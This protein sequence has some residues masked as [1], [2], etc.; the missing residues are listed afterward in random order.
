M[1][2]ITLTRIIGEYKP[3]SGERLSEEECSKRKMQELRQLAEELRKIDTY[4]LEKKVVDLVYEN[5]ACRFTDYRSTLRVYHYNNAT[6]VFNIKYGVAGM[7][8]PNIGQFRFSA[9]IVS[10]NSIEEIAQDLQEK[11]ELK[12]PEMT[13]R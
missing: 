7:Y 5:I 8:C 1:N 4:L 2:D 12:K 6:I 10:E 9:R 11:F 3:L 13:N